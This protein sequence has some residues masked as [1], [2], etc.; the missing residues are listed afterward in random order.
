[1]S[2]LLVSVERPYLK[3]RNALVKYESPTSIAEMS[4]SVSQGHTVINL[5]AIWKGFISGV[6]YAKYEVSVSYGSKFMA[7]VEFFCHRQTPHR[8]EKNYF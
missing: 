8:Q 5:G 4:N 2:K 7:T 3:S 6:K 1:M